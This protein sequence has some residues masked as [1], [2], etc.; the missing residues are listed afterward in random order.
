MRLTILM[1]GI[2]SIVAGISQLIFVMWAGEASWHLGSP[3][4]QHGRMA[5]LFVG[6]PR[7]SAIEGQHEAAL[8]VINTLEVSLDVHMIGAALLLAVGVLLLYLR[9]SCLRHAG[10]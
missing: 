5:D 4:R 2:A 6:H 10:N 9:F 3:I 1:A 8:R 7:Q